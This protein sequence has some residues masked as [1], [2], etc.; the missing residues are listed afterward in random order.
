MD[1]NTKGSRSLEPS[2]TVPVPR[3]T[4]TVI[5]PT[6]HSTLSDPFMLLSTTFHAVEEGKNLTC[7]AVSF[8]DKKYACSVTARHWSI[9]S[10]HLS[11]KIV[12]T[13]SKNSSRLMSCRSKRSM[14][15]IISATASFVVTVV[16]VSRRLRT[17]LMDTNLHSIDHCSA[18]TRRC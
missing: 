3:T 14:E 10:V 9:S 11:W 17:A 18:S 12:L 4:T 13:T 6:S 5:H 1:D 16:K 15:S 8:V 2:G 7:C